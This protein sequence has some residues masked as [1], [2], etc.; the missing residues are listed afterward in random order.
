MRVIRILICRFNR[1]T[2]VSVHKLVSFLGFKYDYLAK[3]PFHCRLQQPVQNPTSDNT[4]I[5]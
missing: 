1:A 4:N 5:L 3:S 2:V